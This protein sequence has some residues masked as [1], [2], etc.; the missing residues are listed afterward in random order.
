MVKGMPILTDINEK[1][2]V[3]RRL[4]VR[5][6]I[7]RRMIRVGSLPD[8]ESVVQVNSPV[9]INPDIFSYRFFLSGLTG[10]SKM[11]IEKLEIV[12]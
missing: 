12:S 2:F 1:T 9:T 3:S 7:Q 4:E 5:I 8:Y 10:G 11:T 6:N